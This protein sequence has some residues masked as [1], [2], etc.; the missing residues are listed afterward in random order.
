MGAADLLTDV[1]ATNAAWVAAWFT[2]SNQLLFG[3]YATLQ[4]NA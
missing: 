2:D 3:T 4:A 1:K